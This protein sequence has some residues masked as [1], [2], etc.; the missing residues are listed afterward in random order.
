MLLDLTCSR[1][2]FPKS[3]DKKK[4][5]ETLLAFKSALTPEQLSSVPMEF[6]D[7]HTYVRNLSAINEPNYEYWRKVFRRCVSPEVIKKPYVWSVTK[8]DQSNR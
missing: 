2:L 7:F 3:A 6:L 5:I 4:K 1:K 8:E